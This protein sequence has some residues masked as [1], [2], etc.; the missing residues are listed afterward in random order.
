MNLPLDYIF[1][2]TSV[3]QQE[4]FF[5]ETGRVSKLFK[6]AKDGYIRILLPVITEKEWLKHFREQAGFNLK[7]SKEIERKLELLGHNESASEFLKHYNILLDSFDVS[8]EI[9][10]NFKMYISY[11]G[12]IKIDY[13]FFEDAI[14]GV[15]DKYFKQ[16][17][18]FGSGGKVKEFPDAFVLAALEKYAKKNKL[19]HIVILSS[20][21]DMSEY[22]CE[23]LKPISISEYLNNLLKERIPDADKK[24]K[25]KKDINNLFNYI[26]SANPKF[27]SALR[28]H[29]EQYLLDTDCYISHFCYADIEDVFDLKFTLD[30]TAKD[31]D[32][33]SVSDDIIEAVCFPE[34]DGTIQVKYFSEEDSLWD[35]EDKEWIVESYKIKKVEISSY[36]P[37]TVRMERDELEQR[38]EPYVE[39]IDIDF[40]P[41]Q[42][43]LDDENYFDK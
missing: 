19:D 12:V 15:F 1:I 27:E 23:L 10:K 2:D 20:D 43:S 13:S 24:A 31:M 3:F 22:V 37:V 17:K 16:E 41:L 34:I 7:K 28:E 29:V 38:E 11:D 5:K 14:A 21:K 8:R 30:I 6:L 42:D 36:F 4:C 35:S 40:R 39:I 26:H 32:I 33:L 25:Q 18:P 9:E